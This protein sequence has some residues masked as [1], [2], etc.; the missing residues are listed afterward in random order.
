MREESLVVLLWSQREKGHKK[1]DV[2]PGPW[3]T[4]CLPGISG[5][6]KGAR[7]EAHGV[8]ASALGGHLGPFDS[9]LGLASFS[10]PSLR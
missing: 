8:G 4:E 1:R 10:D 7:A 3:I 9:V 5:R 6:L 2:S